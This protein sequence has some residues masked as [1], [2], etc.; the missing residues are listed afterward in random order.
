MNSKVYCKAAKPNWKSCNAVFD[1]SF[2]SSFP[3]Q[4]FLVAHYV[5]Y[6]YFKAVLMVYLYPLIH[7]QTNASVHPKSLIAQTTTFVIAPNSS[8]GTAKCA[9]DAGAAKMLSVCPVLHFSHTS[10]NARSRSMAMAWYV[11]RNSS[12]C[13]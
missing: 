8:T 12:L 1:I 13:A 2:S 7:L 6:I 4:T 9:R 5:L 11:Y 10:A 3:I